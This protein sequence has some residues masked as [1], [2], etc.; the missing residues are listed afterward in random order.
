MTPVAELQNPVLEQKLPLGIAVKNVLFATDFSATSE[1]A[2]PYATAVCRHFGSTLHTVHVLPDSTLLMMTGGVDYVS[3]GT[4]YD[5]A[6]ADALKMLDQISDRFE[7]IPHHN[8]VRHGQVW[9]ALAG[10]I[11][12]NKIDLVVVGTH[13][14]SGLGKLLLGSVAE[15]ILRHAPC[16]VLTVGPKVSGR[17]KL[18]TFPNRD[19]APVELELRQILFATD[20]AQY[21]VYVAQ[22]AVALAEEFRARLTLLHVLEDYSRLGRRPD[23]MVECACRLQSLVANDAALQYKP[24]A[25]LEFG[26]PADS[27]LKVAAEREAD[28][29]VLGA[30]SSAQ[31]R[32]THL[33]W[34]TAHLVI[35]QAHCP[36]L[37]VRS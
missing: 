18:P 6:H 1:V 34:T 19:L 35:A 29:I 31:T 4:L 14:R 20:F 22:E 33:P 2:L 23:L 16:P 5:D 17:A 21:S 28:M 37:T 12:E 13:G 26:F 27:I 30:R 7:G 15:D 9:R 3:M 10:M 32:T 24:E 8:Y 11:A 36:V 25:L